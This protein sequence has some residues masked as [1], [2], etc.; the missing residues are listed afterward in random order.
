[1]KICVL[2]WGSLWWDPRTLKISDA[3]QPVG[4]TVPIEFSRISG[5][6][7][8][9]PRLALVIDEANGSP[10]R[11]SVAQSSFDDLESAMENLRDREGMLHV[12]GVGFVEVVSGNMGLRAKERHPNAVESIRGWLDGTDFD[13]AIWTALASNFAEA[14]E[15]PFSIAA[16]LRF[17]E[18]LPQESQS[19]A[20][21]YIERAPENTQTAVRHEVAK[22]WKHVSGKA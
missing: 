11:T 15:E 21:E 9:S 2:A 19:T 6:N 16:V 8:P 12:D 22:R 14:C 18:S 3:F 20:L 13:V 7:G 10:C 17:L 4:P 1:M 5:K